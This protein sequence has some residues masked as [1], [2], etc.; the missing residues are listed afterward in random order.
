[1]TK[2]SGFNFNVKVK[3][4]KVNKI[5]K[6]HGLDTNG[7][8]STFFRNEV[9]RLM[10]P[11]V[12]GGAGGELEKLKTYPDNTQI[13]YISPYAH[14]QYTGNEY[15]SPKLG[16]SGILLKK[17]DVWW[18]PKGEKKKKTGKKLTYHTSGTGAKWDRLMLKKHKKNIIKD[19]Q[20]YIKS[21]GK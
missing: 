2:S 21:G 10:G 8:V 14:Y 18:S 13:K 3:I 6:A 16:V 9:D 17:Y 20:T 5:I 19:V 15:I 11:F 7:N 1:M 12:P 4:K